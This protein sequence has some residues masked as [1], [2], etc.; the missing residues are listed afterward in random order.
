VHCGMIATYQGR[1]ADITFSA[2][3]VFSSSSVAAAL[4]A[5]SAQRPGDVAPVTPPR[6]AMVEDI[7]HDISIIIR[8]EKI[9][10]RLLEYGVSQLSSMRA[11][12][13]KTIWRSIK[14]RLAWRETPERAQDDTTPEGRGIH[15][16]ERIISYALDGYTPF[17]MKKG[18]VDPWNPTVRWDTLP[19]GAVKDSPETEWFLWIARVVDRIEDEGRMNDFKAEG[20]KSNP[21]REK[22]LEK[23]VLKPSARHTQRRRESSISTALLSHVC[24]PGALRAE[25]I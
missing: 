9:L 1:G 21:Y 12:M 14:A 23:C 11:A 3:T 17:W 24:L 25:L 6:T 20:K 13:A 5:G 19:R 2:D 16:M 10:S 18:V 7:E 4:A 8:K 15:S 22:I